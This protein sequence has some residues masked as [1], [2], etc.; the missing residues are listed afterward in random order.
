MYI[1]IAI[2]SIEIHHL[3]QTAAYIETLQESTIIGCINTISYYWGQRNQYV[4]IQKWFLVEYSHDD[5]S[6]TKL[7]FAKQFL[8]YM[9][10]GALNKTHVSKF[11]DYVPLG[12]KSDIFTYNNL[13]LNYPVA[14]F[15]HGSVFER[16]L[17][18]ELFICHQGGIY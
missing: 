3:G 8:G 14:A 5:N 15:M 4:H 16:S 9:K 6:F 2:C 7:N 12:W 1:L 11:I 18:L 17:V 10:H 13:V